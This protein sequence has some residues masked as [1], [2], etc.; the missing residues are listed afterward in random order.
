MG[1]VGLFGILSYHTTPKDIISDEGI[2]NQ[3]LGICNQIH[4]IKNL[5]ENFKLTLLFIRRNVDNENSFQEKFIFSG[6]RNL[7]LA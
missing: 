2:W 1:F 4:I 7:T 6:C 3:M 5:S